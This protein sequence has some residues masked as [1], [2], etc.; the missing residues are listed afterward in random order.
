MCDSVICIA[1]CFPIRMNY[2]LAVANVPK[3]D[4]SLS[5]AAVGMNRGKSGNVKR[6]I[7]NMPKAHPS[8]VVLEL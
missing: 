6:N 2:V 7:R 5:S 8:L 1:S 3:I 4:D